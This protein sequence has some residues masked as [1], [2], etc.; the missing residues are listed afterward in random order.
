M[1][2]KEKVLDE[3]GKFKTYLR[4]FKNKSD[5]KINY[6]NE[7]ENAKKI[8]GSK[9]YK[10]WPLVVLVVVLLFIGISMN[11]MNHSKSELI[12]RFEKAVESN[13]TSKM[14]SIIKLSNNQ[15]IQKDG[16]IPVLDFFEADQSRISELKNAFKTGKPCFSMNLKKEKKLI[17]ENYYIEV[18]TKKLEID[19]NLDNTTLII[20]GKNEG[21][22]N[23]DRT[24]DLIAPGDYNIELEHK[25]KYSTIQTSKKISFTKDS[26]VSMELKGTSV[27]VKTNVPDATVY[28]N[29]S[30]TGVVAKDFI[31]IGPFPSDST[32]GISL[33]YNTPF[34]KVSSDIV[35]ISDMPSVN[36]NIDLKTSGIET[37]LN[38]LVGKFYE[39]VFNAID[40][41]DQNK[42]EYANDEA[43]NKIYTDIKEKGFILKNVY[44]LNSSSI[45]FDKST[46]E[47]KDGVYY[48]NVVASI[49]YNVK[50]EI[51][52]VPLKTNDYTQ[53]FFTK[54]KYQNG[55]WE[56]YDI[57]NFDL[58]ST[59]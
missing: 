31:D 34:G 22:F 17:G 15:E 43:K 33:K 59:Q 45:D 7:T 18:S 54:A 2:L 56:I 51:L 48:A 29:D 28:I 19:S 4:N 6:L 46:I 27:S 35:K 50:K 30:S 39:S 24:I 21:E 9:Y 52:G 36:L 32:Y 16:I 5:E 40:L 10:F 12:S 25:N 47:L 49:D 13:S 37:S 57:E 3:L 11:M 53:N 26:K 41:K 23:K 8:K 44:K 58:K 42:I 38:N 20:N 1:T 14:A 55:K